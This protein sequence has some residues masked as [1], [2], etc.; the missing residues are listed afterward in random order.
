MI[1]KNANVVE[2]QVSEKCIEFSAWGYA[3]YS[4]IVYP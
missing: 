2:L 4:Q 1:C 3:F